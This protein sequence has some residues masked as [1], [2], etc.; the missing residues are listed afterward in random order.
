MSNGTGESKKNVRAAVRSYL[1]RD[2]DSFREAFFRYARLYY[3]DKV[4]DFSENGFGGLMM[5]LAAWIG[6][7]QAF[8]LDHLYHE[9]DLETAREVESIERELRKAGVPIIGAAPAVVDQDFVF[10]VPA[11]IVDNQIVP[12]P[13]ALPIIRSVG[14]VVSADNGIN[15]ELTEDIDFTEVDVNNNLK[16]KIQISKRDAQGKPTSFLVSR[17]GYCISGKRV[18]ETFQ[19][20]NFQPFYRYTLSN[21]NVSEIISIVDDLGNEYFEVGSLSED[22]VFRAI[23]N[24]A[25][26]N[27]IVKEVLIPYVALYRFTRDTVLGTR[28]STLTF[29]GGNG[30]DAEISTLIDPGTMAIPLYGK[31]VFNRVSV[32]PNSLINTK[33]LGIATPNSTFTITYRY[34]GGLQHNAPKETI[35]AI[36]SINLDFTNNPQNTVSQRVRSSVATINRE[37]ASGAD[38]APTVDT[39]K[40]LA[41]FFK[42]SQKRVVAREDL[43]SRVYTLPSNF[44]RVFR[45][46]VHPIENNPLA[47]GLYVLTRDIEGKLTVASDSLKKN[48]KNYLKTFRL[49][50][51]AIEIFDGRIINL[52][53][54]IKISVHPDENRNLVVQQV[55]N[56]LIKFFNLRKFE[57]DQ[58]IS[59]DDIRNIA[60]NTPGVLSIVDIQFTV[61]KNTE[62]RTYSDVNF[63]PQSATKKNMLFPPKGGIFEIRYP[64]YDIVGISV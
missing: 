29:G 33:S 56:K 28:Q 16:A 18:T 55:V 46:T 34:G 19:M 30:S 3:G 6:D 60:Y 23:P 40:R 50:T 11:A 47:T 9:K 20:G 57:M 24:I 49:T 54:Q 17:S 15:F 44:G 35:R 8:Y 12:D 62:N 14:T 42:S 2:F 43:I 48:I 5:E 7:N 4:Q 10:E 13:T 26:D 25:Y 37:K 61:P 45:A 27:E 36:Q 32:N 64:V 31:T 22:T 53:L 51:D 1:N 38:D 58:L 39:L 21:P 52:G 59:I 63:D 41:P